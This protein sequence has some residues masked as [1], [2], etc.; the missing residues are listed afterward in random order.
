MSREPQGDAGHHSTLGDTAHRAGRFREAVEE[1]RKSLSCD[2]NQPQV[3]YAAGWAE[4]SLGEFAAAASSFRNALEINPDWPEARHNLGRA[5]FKLGQIEEALACFRQAAS[6]WG[7]RPR[8]G[9]A[10]AVPGTAC[11]G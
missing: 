1:Y 11:V 9:I 7:E 5:C 10:V 3:W 8:G 6:S 4:I 2:W